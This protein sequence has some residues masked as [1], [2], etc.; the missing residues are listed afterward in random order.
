MPTIKDVAKEAGLGVG[1]VSRYL[2]GVRL[3]ERN[4]LAIENAIEKLGYNRNALARSMKTGRSMTIAVIVPHL[5]NMFS[6]RVIESIERALENQEY[7][8]L[9]SD[10]DDDGR[11]MLDKLTLLKNKMVDGFVL[12]AP[13]NDSSGIKERVGDTP[14]VLIDRTLDKEIFDSVT[15]NNREAVYKTISRVLNRG[16]EKIGIIKGPQA[17]S[18][19]RERNEG[20]A[21]ALEKRGIKVYPSVEGGYTVKSGFECMQ[22]LLKE[23]LEAVF[24]S[25][26]ELT[27]GALNAINQSGR[28]LQVIGFDSLELENAIR[29]P[30][31][32]ISQ[33]IEA[34]GENAAKL[35]LQRINGTRTTLS[36]TVLDIPQA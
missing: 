15:V 7:S 32:S 9:V 31:L 28:Q 25:N 13:S 1:T 26:Y 30:I 22:M 14:L 27:L 11:K 33:P 12:M 4:R 24:T 10:C 18:T 6:M 23:E 3:K 17:I 20:F 19:A 34:I 21:Q 35:L 16:V 2:N 8:V 29:T 36:H 5:A